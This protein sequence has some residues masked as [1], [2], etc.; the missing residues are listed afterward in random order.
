MMN[1]VMELPSQ[2]LVAEDECICAFGLSFFTHVIALL[3]S[4][5]SADIYC[6]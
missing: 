6:R 2:F 3:I 1:E 4:N 5:M